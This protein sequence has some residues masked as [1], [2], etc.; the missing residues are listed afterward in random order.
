MLR[1]GCSGA[2]DGHVAASYDQGIS[3]LTGVGKTAWRPTRSDAPTANPTPPYP[4]PDAA[5]IKRLVTLSRMEQPASPPAGEA[6]PGSD[7][8]SVKLA[9]FGQVD[10]VAVCCRRGARR[11][12]VPPGPARRTIGDELAAF[13]L[14]PSDLSLE[15]FER[16]LDAFPDGQRR[17]LL[18]TDFLL[19][20]GFDALI[21]SGN[22]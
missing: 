4:Q 1:S 14:D 21:S 16:P 8:A 2:F 17:G 15:V 19:G 9:E 20:V 6:D 13:G 5:S 10:P 18:E 7:W 3:H 11:G 22:R 12:A